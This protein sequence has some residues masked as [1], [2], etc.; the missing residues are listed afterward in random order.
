ML[1]KRPAEHSGG[2]DMQ[3]ANKLYQLDLRSQTFRGRRGWLLG[4]L[5]STGWGCNCRGI[6]F[7]LKEALFEKRSIDL[8]VGIFRECLKCHPAGREHIVGHEFLQMLA[9][10]AEADIV[11]GANHVSTTNHPSSEIVGRDGH[12]RAFL[13]LAHRIQ[14]GL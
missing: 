10:V 1:R 7:V 5:R 6:A 12:D 11:A 14:S 3:T 8:S 4:G 2:G 9:Q 13:K